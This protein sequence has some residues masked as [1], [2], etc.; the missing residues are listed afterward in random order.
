M[1]N[2]VTSFLKAS[3]SK[4]SLT[5]DGWSSIGMKGYY[6]ITAHFVDKNWNIQ[7]IVLDFVPAEGSHTGASTAN[8]LF[9][10]LKS[11]DL[12]DCIQ[13]VTTDNAAV[14]FTMMRS[15]ETL[16]PGFDYKNKHFVCFAHIL[17]L[18][19]QDFMKVVEPNRDIYILD[20]EKDLEYL[21]NEIEAENDINDTD[22]NCPVSKIRYLV[23]KNKKLRA[24]AT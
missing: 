21:E 8:I 3:G 2:S 12:L 14:N 19:V 24:D 1:K 11:F 15:L 13:G 6:G 23:K 5:I 9:E 20:T 18:A 7:S 16:V 22:F 4:I 10:V 17:N